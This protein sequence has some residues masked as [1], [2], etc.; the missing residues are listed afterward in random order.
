[1]YLRIEY[2]AMTVARAFWLLAGHLWSFV[3]SLKSDPFERFEYESRAAESFMLFREAHRILPPEVKQ[4]VVMG[5]GAIVC[6]GMLFATL[7]FRLFFP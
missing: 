3:A 4:R 1:M 2:M 7:D 5:V 6:L